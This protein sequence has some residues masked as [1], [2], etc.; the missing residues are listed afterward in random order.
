MFIFYIFTLIPLAIYNTY[1][2]FIAEG[3]KKNNNYDI[4]L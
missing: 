3:L 4:D 2:V 1:T